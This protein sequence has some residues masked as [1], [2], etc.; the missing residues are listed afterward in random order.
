MRKEYFLIITIVLIGLFLYSCRFAELVFYE[1]RP[2][3][4][5]YQSKEIKA[6]DTE[7][8]SNGILF[9]VDVKA[10]SQR[11][12]MIFWLG[13]YSENEGAQ[14]EIAKA[15][16]QGPGGQKEVS[17]NRTLS[18]SEQDSD[19]GN[20]YKAS[21]KLFQLDNNT[22]EILCQKSESIWL[23]ITYFVGGKEEHKRFNLN[24]R[25]EKQPVFS[26]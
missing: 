20:L 8:I 10:V 5:F 7:F 23:D 22:V 2:S 18:L 25:I 17:I 12:E 3:K 14:M 26:T 9:V 1:H 16:L 19:K 6:A 13:L 15:V 24:R 11:E 4:S 21:I